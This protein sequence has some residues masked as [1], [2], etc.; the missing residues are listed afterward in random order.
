MTTPA[1]FDPDSIPQTGFDPIAFW[2]A[3][4]TKVII[5]S[6]VIIIAI[7]AY[8]Y[9]EISAERETEQSREALAQAG[10]EDDYRQVIQKFPHAVAAGDASLLL[11]EKLRDA[12]KYDDATA[13]LQAMIDTNPDHP[14]IDGAWLSLASTYNAEGKPDQAVD[15][16]KQIST[17]FADRYSAPMALY[18]V[19]EILKSE[20][21]LDDAKIAYENVKS[22]FPESYFAS[23]AIQKL[24]LLKK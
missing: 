7:V 20:G 11:A 10:S 23:E 2:L 5:Y 6:A 8:A 16:Y 14:L 17:K 21:K 13:V 15:T 22:Q 4:K 18:S 9:H 12:K 19:A 1:P 3:H 24:Q